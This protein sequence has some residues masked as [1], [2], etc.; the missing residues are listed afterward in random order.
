[1]G[2]E[3]DENGDDE[4]GS[5]GGLD[6]TAGTSRGSK[7][8]GS[9]R[10]QPSCASSSASSPSGEEEEDLGPDPFSMSEKARARYQ[11]IF[12]K[13][14]ATGTGSLNGKQ[15]I[16]LFTKSGLDKTALAVIWRLSDLDEDGSLSADEFGIA[17]HLIFCAT[18]RK[19]NVPDELPQSLWPAGYVP[20]S[21]LARRKEEAE[22][23]RKQEEQERRRREK[24]V[25]DSSGKSNNDAAAGTTKKK[26]K[27]KSKKIGAS[28]KGTE[29][30][31]GGI[32]NE[33]TEEDKKKEERELRAARE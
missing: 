1:M 15:V 2:P 5:V 32:G 27:D 9:G 10:S 25:A 24:T 4:S 20:P 28:K 6:S 29:V 3:N 16:G 11:A 18:Q 30:A 26:K 7:W 23:K 21:V 14:D 13:V 12:C 31:G 8:I 22:K 17:F 33:K 19:L